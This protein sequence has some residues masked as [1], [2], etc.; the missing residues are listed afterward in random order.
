MEIG[1]DTSVADNL[2][3]LDSETSFAALCRVSLVKPSSGRQQYRRL[4]RGG[5][6]QANAA[7]HHIVFTRLRVDPQTQDYYK[8]WIKE[9]KTRHEVVRCPK[10]Y[11]AQEI[12]WSDSHSQ[13]PAHGSCCCCEEHRHLCPRVPLPAVIYGERAHWISSMCGWSGDA[14][15]TWSCKS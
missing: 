5:D 15:Q 14:G 2:E 3:R 8:R 7:L 4:N 9:A 13:A 1:P 11:A 10:R 6:R 12:T